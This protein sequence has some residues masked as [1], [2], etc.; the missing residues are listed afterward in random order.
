[1]VLRTLTL[2]GLHRILQVHFSL[3]DAMAA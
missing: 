1:M 2:M 3:D